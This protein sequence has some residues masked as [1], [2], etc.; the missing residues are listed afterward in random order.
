M[1]K[2]S[3]V[4]RNAALLKRG[5]IYLV[6]FL[7]LISAASTIIPRVFPGE[8]AEGRVAI[9][10]HNGKIIRKIELDKVKEAARITIP[11]DYQAEQEE[12]YG[13]GQRKDHIGGYEAV[14]LVEKGRIRFEESN[15]PDKT[16]IKTGWLEKPG[17]S[18]VCLPGRFMIKI[19]GI[20]DEV[21][22]V[23]Y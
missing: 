9:I 20:T 2:K 1:S 11:G 8:R 10:K 21:D 17:D 14:V 22:G 12:D 7:V 18:A 23:T 13:T 4:K 15:C 16:C 3:S 6:I 5:D 19:E